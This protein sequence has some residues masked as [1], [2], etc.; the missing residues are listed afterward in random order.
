ML[1]TGPG[2][3]AN[4]YLFLNLDHHSKKPVVSYTVLCRWVHPLIW[5][6]VSGFIAWSAGVHFITF[7]P[8]ITTDDM[9][10]MIQYLQEVRRPPL[11]I[12]CICF[13][14]AL[15]ILLSLIHI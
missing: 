15:H 10:T 7:A 6:V 4:W 11:H 8:Q 14:Y 12:F 9:T 5:L 13:A 2:F 1:S 3:I